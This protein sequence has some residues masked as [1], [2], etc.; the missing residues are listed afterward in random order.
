MESDGGNE[1][2]TAGPA[3]R[4]FLERHR[5]AQIAPGDAGLDTG[6]DNDRDDDDNEAKDQGATDGELEIDGSGVEGF[7]AVVVGVDV[8]ATVPLPPKNMFL[9]P[10]PRAKGVSH[11]PV[12]TRAQVERHALEQHVNYAP[13]CPHCLQAS[14]LTR[15][16]A[17]V[18]GESPSMPTV[19]ADFCFMKR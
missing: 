11:P 19:S 4:R 10:R 13:W 8:E 18:T 9:A 17:L 14:A 15:K 6:E 2:P 16:H 3:A 1:I 5:P 7:P 12:P